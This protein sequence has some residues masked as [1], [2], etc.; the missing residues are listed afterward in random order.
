MSKKLMELREKPNVKSNG[1]YA[2]HSIQIK[3]LYLSHLI[4][5]KKIDESTLV[6]N[7]FSNLHSGVRADIALVKGN[8]TEAIEIKSAFDSLRRLENQIKIYLECFNKVTIV[9]E[10]R[11]LENVMTATHKTNAGVVLFD[12]NIFSTVKRPTKSKI[13]RSVI[14]NK[15]TPNIFEAKQANQSEYINY[16]REKYSPNM[17]HVKRMID[18]GHATEADVAQLNPSRIRR[19][20]FNE[21]ERSIEETWYS[22]TAGL[23]VNP[24]FLSKLRD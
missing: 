23:Q 8:I 2:Q 7:E 13:D 18:K 24:F 6:I 4:K 12:G 16:I 15:L 3:S 9:T 22:L 14:T 11:H 10:K 21:K 1:N 20:R 17:E 19:E 5:A